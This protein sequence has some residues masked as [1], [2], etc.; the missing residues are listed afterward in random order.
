MNVPLTATP[1]PRHPAL[2][3]ELPVYGQL[4]RALSDAPEAAAWRSLDG[5]DWRR[6][7]AVAVEEGVAP[8]LHRLLPPQVPAPEAVRGALQRAYY[9]TAAQNALLFTELARV[10]ENL[11]Q[12]GVPVVVMKGADLAHSL[13]PDPALRPMTD[14]DLLTT[15]QHLRLAL[16]TLAGLGYRKLNENFVH[17]HVLL[18]GGPGGNVAVELHWSLID[19]LESSGNSLTQEQDWFWR[20]SIPWS[21]PGLPAGLDALALQPH[22][23]LLYLSAHLLLQHPGAK[24]RLV[25]YYDLYLLLQ[26]HA[27]SLDWSDL[28]LQARRLGWLG[29]VEEA[30][31]AVSARFGL[32]LPQAYLEAAAQHLPLERAADPARPP[33]SPERFTRPRSV[34]VWEGLRSRSPAERLRLLW[35]VIFPEPAYLRWRYRLRPTWLW[36]LA[37]FYRWFDILLDGI[38]TFTGPKRPR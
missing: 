8:L 37:Y 18:H 22:A 15:P 31:Q 38:T 14:L 36:P 3:S 35:D 25:W 23:C 11:R 19:P 2:R 34:L 7:A 12:A 13:Y 10:L 32:L 29:L 9:S 4:C 5:E 6:L 30:L 1:L 26:R 24:G 16:R 33:A 21:A 28:L 20:R 17:H 27:T